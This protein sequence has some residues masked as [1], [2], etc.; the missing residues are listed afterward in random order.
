MIATQ[1]RQERLRQRCQMLKEADQ[2]LIDVIQFGSS[3]YAP[4]L[5]RDIDLLVTTHAKKDEEVYWDIFSG[6][7][8][9]ADVLVRTPEQPMGRDIAANVW[10]LGNVLFGT[11]ETL[12]QAEV[13][14]AVP[15][16]DRAHKSL[17]T[18]DDILALAQQKKDPI[19]RDEHYRVAFDRLFDASRYAAM[20]FLSTANSR[21]GQLRH[22]LPSPLNEQFRGF[23]NTL[24]IQ[25]SY[26]GNYP[27][28][29]PDSAFTQARQ[30]VE[31]FIASLEKIQTTTP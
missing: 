16:F 8:I 10:L 2:N 24:H 27:Q 26:D 5:A 19:L 30:E 18:A 22:A 6:L 9:G 29:D 28:Q 14:M 11:G 3:V 20:A 21:W 1:K 31:Q 12:K 25:Y 7:D 23:I 17:Q 4:D 15:T 13:F